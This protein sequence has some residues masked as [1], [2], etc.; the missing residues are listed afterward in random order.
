MILKSFKS[1]I[2]E[3]LYYLSMSLGSFQ[4]VKCHRDGLIK[5][6]ERYQIPNFHISTISSL[7][8]LAL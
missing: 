6:C 5:M 1:V 2:Q 4:D 7:D 3:H 8:D